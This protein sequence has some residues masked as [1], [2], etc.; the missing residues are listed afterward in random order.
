MVDQETRVVEVPWIKWAMAQVAWQFMRDAIREA[1]D[2]DWYFS[3]TG[4]TIE[5]SVK[6]LEAL[7]WD[8]RPEPR[9]PTS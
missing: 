4:S 8:C 9:D 2:G 5:R 3:G 1:P 6:E 7:L